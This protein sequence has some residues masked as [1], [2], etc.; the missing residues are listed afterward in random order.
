[1][2]RVHIGLNLE[3]EAGKRCFGRLYHACAGVP[4]LW[5]WR[6]VEQGLQD[7]LYAE[8]VDPGTEENRRLQT[9]QKIDQIK[10]AAR[11]ADEVDVFT[12][13]ANF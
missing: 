2:F 12:Q 4:F 6:P 10:G 9:G 3:Y 13:F 7:F 1:M 8:V 5:W 11:T